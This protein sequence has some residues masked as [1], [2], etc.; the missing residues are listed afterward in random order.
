MTDTALVAVGAA[1][2]VTVFALVGLILAWKVLD[3]EH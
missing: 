1:M 3:R 2:I